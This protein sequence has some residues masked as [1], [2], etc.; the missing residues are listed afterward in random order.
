MTPERWQSVNELYHAAQ[1]RAPHER[2]AWL[3]ARCADDE[4]LY[5]EV[6]ALLAADEKAADYLETP[7][8]ELEAKALAAEQPAATPL[9]QLAQ[10]EI[11]APLG[12]G[13][14]GEVHLALD[15]RLGRKVALKLLPAAFTT[16]AERVR[17]FA[18]EAHAV[19]A[20]NHPNIITIHEIGEVENIHYIVTE[21]VAGETLR[22][23]M[24]DA[25]HQRMTTSKA[26]DLAVQIATA[27]A[28]AHEAG[29]RN[30]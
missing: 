15:T 4:A 21:Y 18:R 27:L 11:L 6:T 30:S 20:L 22:Q 14:M 12:A 19:S 16:E 9:R 23:C 5:R 13:G 24:L 3:R 8:L 7:A 2:E 28:A 17:R 25:P 10:Y 29:M 1:E 26:V